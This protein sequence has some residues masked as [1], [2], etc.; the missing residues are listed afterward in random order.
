MLLRN[1]N[2]WNISSTSGLAPSGVLVSPRA[3]APFSF[4][5]GEEDAEKLPVCVCTRVTREPEELGK[6]KNT[7]ENFGT[8]TSFLVK[9]SKPADY[10][11]L[12]IYM[13]RGTDQSSFLVEI[14]LKTS[15]EGGWLGGSGMQ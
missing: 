11:Y 3:R 14:S 7:P 15:R 8:M 12:F 10:K 1:R 6:K 13:V 2:P 4:E 9:I 5:E